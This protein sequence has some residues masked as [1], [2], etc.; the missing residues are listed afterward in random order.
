LNPTAAITSKSGKRRRYDRL[1]V[2]ENIT[3]AHYSIS[4]TEQSV[5]ISSEVKKK[6]KKK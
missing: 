2:S 6:K 4:G 3:P 5:Q 1:L